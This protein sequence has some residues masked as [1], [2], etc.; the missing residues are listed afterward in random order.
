MSPNDGYLVIQNSE[1]M[2]GV[3]DKAT[4]GDGNKKSVFAV[5]QRDYGE[6]EAASAMNK[7][8]KVCARW[9]GESLMSLS[10]TLEATR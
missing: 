10:P 3:M 2:C 8:A 1:I 6:D 4:V 9:L 7:M 5:I